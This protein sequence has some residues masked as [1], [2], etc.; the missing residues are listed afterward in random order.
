MFYKMKARFIRSIA[1]IRIPSWVM[2]VFLMVAF[3]LSA[4]SPLGNKPQNTLEVLKPVMV[5]ETTLVEEDAA[6]EISSP[7][8]IAAPA[9]QTPSAELPSPTYVLSVEPTE[10]EA[11]PSPSQTPT[12]DVRLLPKDWRNWPIV[13]TVSAHAIALYQSGVDVGNDPQKFSVIGD[14]QSVPEVFLG[15]YETDRYW[16]GDDYI[17]LS[18]T[19]DYYLGSYSHESL[20]VKGGM[21][22]STALSPLWADQGVCDSTE[23]PVECELRVY[24]PSIVFINLGT[25][26]RADASTVPYEKYLR[27]I[28][29]MV[30]ARG[31]LPILMTKADNVEG[32]FSINLITARVAY[33]YDVPLLNFWAAA[34][35]LKHNGLDESTNFIYLTPEGWDRRNFVA[36]QTLDA[37]RRQLE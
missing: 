18:E 32:D 12:A 15:I 28:V 30:V 22:A 2:M 14:C 31:T 21:S 5:Q 20:A 8:M 24:Q 17:Y 6:V 33:D 4:C 37:V 27:Q 7:T 35:S 29:D 26:W 23:S 34:Q 10:T 11:A 13:P 3:L 25:N 36:L 16:L 1:V 9:E 19:I